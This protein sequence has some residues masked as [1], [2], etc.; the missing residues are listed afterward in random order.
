MSG[1]EL[2]T[3][4][5]VAASAAQLVDY[6]LKLIRTISEIYNRAKDAE[7]RLVRY[8]SQ[9]YQILEVGR[10]IQDNE[11]LQSPL[12][13]NQLQC[14]LAEVK[15]LD[16]DLGVI[17]L[18][19][20]TGSGRRRAWKA[21][22]G[23]KEKRILESFETL[24]KEKTALIL[25]IVVVHNH[26]LQGIGNSVDILVKR[27]MGISDFIEKVKRKGNKDK[28]KGNSAITEPE[29]QAA[30]MPKSNTGLPRSPAKS[31][32]PPESSK[33]GQP[34]ATQGNQT[35]RHGKASGSASQINGD[36]KTGSTTAYS[37]DGQSSKDQSFQVNG[38][39]GG[40]GPHKH[41]NQDAAGNSIQ[42]NGNV[43][44]EETET[45]IRKDMGK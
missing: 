39:Y 8:T 27:E 42:I 22:V 12:V 29:D 20:T 18:D 23:N 40:S 30:T 43:G 2:I 34:P 33:L 16:R 44:G 13:H 31:G 45:Q 28:Q 4:I 21:I 11:D 26:H 14:T 19:Y 1:L 3:V 15:Q 38:N 10:A 24:E 37:Y 7:T 41:Q 9:I 25:C 6:S 32:S 36:Y 17:Y 5:G 35:Y